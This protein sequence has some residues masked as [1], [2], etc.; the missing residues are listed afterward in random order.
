[1]LKRY[2]CL[3]DVPTVLSGRLLPRVPKELWPWAAGM[4][5]M[6]LESRVLELAMERLA[7]AGVVAMPLGDA[8]IV[9]VSAAGSL[10]RMMSR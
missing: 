5:L 1:M 8:L 9:P 6:W 10:D 4:H 3:M 7:K 2:P